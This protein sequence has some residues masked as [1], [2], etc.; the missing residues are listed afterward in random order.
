MNKISSYFERIMQI[1]DFYG[2]KNPND[3]AK[4]ALGYSS[5]EK[6]NRLKDENKKPSIDILLDIS[7]KFEEISMDW[8]LTGKGDLLKNNNTTNQKTDTVGDNYLNKNALEMIR[9]LSAENALL[10]DKIKR[11]NNKNYPSLAAES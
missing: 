10:K 11:L 8:L 2:Y 3:F 7:N 5:P 9:D 4:N 6:I 1:A